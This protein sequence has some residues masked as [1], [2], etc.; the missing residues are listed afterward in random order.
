MT[1][2]TSAY[3]YTTPTTS[4]P[5][6]PSSPRGPCLLKSI[7]RV[8]YQASPILQIYDNG[9]LVIQYSPGLCKALQHTHHLHVGWLALPP[10]LLLCCHLGL[11]AMSSKFH[12]YGGVSGGATAAEVVLEVP[13]ELRLGREEGGDDEREEKPTL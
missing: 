9:K 8:T 12:N 11:Q 2:C 5:A 3:E 6:H 7:L 1:I 4:I 10:S 13:Q